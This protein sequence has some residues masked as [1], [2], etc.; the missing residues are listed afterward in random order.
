M[1]ELCASGKAFSQ[2]TC[3]TIT[4]GRQRIRKGLQYNE[5]TIS[6][7]DGVNM[8]WPCALYIVYFIGSNARCL[9]QEFREAV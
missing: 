8:T 2:I 6:V 5:R 4:T 3:F 1:K 7:V 9:R